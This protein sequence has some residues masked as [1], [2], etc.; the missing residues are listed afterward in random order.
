MFSSSPVEK[1]VFPIRFRAPPTVSVSSI[2]S[3]PSHYN[4][5]VH[6][7]CTVMCQKWLMKHC[8]TQDCYAQGFLNIFIGGKRALFDH[9]NNRVIT[10]GYRGKTMVW[11]WPLSTGC[12]HSPHVDRVYCRK[13]SCTASNDHIGHCRTPVQPSVAVKADPFHPSLPLFQNESPEWRS[14]AGSPATQFPTEEE[15]SWPRPKTV[16]LR[17]TPQGFGFTLR[18]F[19]VY[20]PESSMHLFLVRLQTRVSSARWPYVWYQRSKLMRVLCLLLQEDEHGGRGKRKRCLWC[21]ACEPRL[22]WV[23]AVPLTS[24]DSEPIRSLALFWFLLWWRQCRSCL[25]LTSAGGWKVCSAPP[26]SVPLRP[27]SLYCSTFVFLPC[28]FF[29][30][31]CSQKEMASHL[32]RCCVWPSFHLSFWHPSVVLFTQPTPT[33]LRLK[34]IHTAELHAIMSETR[35]WKH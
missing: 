24:T 9:L 16:L 10:L 3:R 4:T 23:G 27:T 8:S 20:P 33:H 18:H 2:I 13:S 1:C 17:R 35:E 31:K 21:S 12:W 25:S 6:F 34:Q 7:I 11:F 5:K 28:F 15:F 29:L 32:Q 19:I 14:L 22:C 26:A 30:F